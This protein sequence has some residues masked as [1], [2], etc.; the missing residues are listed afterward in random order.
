MI[1]FLKKTEIVSI[2]TSQ[3]K[4]Y[5][6]NPRNN[7]QAVEFVANSIKEFGFKVPIVI[8]K[9]NEIVCGHT[10]YKALKK[11]GFDKAPCIIADDLNE[12]QIKAFRLA[13][14]KVGEV[15]TW[16]FNQLA[17]ELDDITS[18]DM[19]EFNFDVELPKD[20]EFGEDFSLA[21]GDKSE[22]CQ[23]TFTLHERQ[24][25]LIEYALAQVGSD[26]SETFGNSNKN[27]NALYEVVRQW[28]KQKK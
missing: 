11:L 7:D 14:N 6:N 16:D 20:E 12:E 13:D 1:F 10:R 4:E 26:V 17:V 3:I 9:N 24:K 23:M 22:I 21:D 5:K 15:S 28:A 2:P 8:D 18:I 19:S 27:G 25:E